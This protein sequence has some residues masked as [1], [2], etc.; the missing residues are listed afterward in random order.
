MFASLQQIVEDCLAAFRAAGHVARLDEDGEP[1]ETAME[2][3]DYDTGTGHNG[4]ICEKCGDSVCIWC[5]S[6]DREI[7]G[8]IGPCR[9][10]TTAA[11]KAEQA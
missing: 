2:F 5:W 1:D 9:G 6:N 8:A 11:S 3:D 10:I 4:Y 7:G